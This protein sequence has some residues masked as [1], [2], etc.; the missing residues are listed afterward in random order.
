MKGYIIA[1][2]VINL[3]QVL[4]IIILKKEINDLKEKINYE[5]NRNSKKSR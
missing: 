4:A 1:F 2:V 3:G 5:I